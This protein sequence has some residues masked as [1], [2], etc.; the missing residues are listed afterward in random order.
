MKEKIRFEEP[1][2]AEEYSG[3]WYFVGGILSFGIV[4]TAFLLIT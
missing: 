4:L 3:A 2:I 1:E